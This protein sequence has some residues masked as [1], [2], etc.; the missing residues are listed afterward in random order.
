MSDNLALENERAS[1][2]LPLAVGGVLVVLVLG[3]LVRFLDTQVPHWLTDTPFERLGKAIEFPVYA[4]ALGLIGNLVLGRLGVRE[5]LS[6]G[7][8]T[9]FFIKTGLVLL[10]A[11]VDLKVL[12]T[13]AGPAIIQAIL[14]ITIVFG[15]TWWFAGRLGID[16]KLRALLASAVSICGVSA[17]IAAAGAVQAKKEQLA[18][19]A[20]LV[21]VFALPSIFLLP[22]LAGVFGLS[23]AVAGAWI[24]GNIDTTAAVAASG[25]IAGE[26]ALQIATIVKTT[27]N[28]LIG[29]VAI[30][31]TAYFALKVERTSSA[32]PT[33]GDFW[34]RFPKFVLGFVAA[35]IIGTLWVAN[36]SGGKADVTTIN[37][38][39]TWFLIF[40][41]VSIGLEFSASGI[42]EAGWRP[43]A[44]FGSATVVNIVV[45]LG[46]A[47]VL[48]GNFELPTT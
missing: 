30:A 14:L 48:F 35:S 36:V 38:L 20:S 25:A 1:R 31:L 8:R 28:A 7:Y 2:G 32:R 42:R 13:A 45:A 26:D 27:Q 44:V 5:K 6:G 33:V 16:D 34:A 10:G 23:D 19:S 41:F 47:T 17:A 12:V 11:S 18:Y 43:I 46:L 15:F 39:R 40:A 29:V 22:W 4:I 24:G 37:D 9:E 3:A 21:I